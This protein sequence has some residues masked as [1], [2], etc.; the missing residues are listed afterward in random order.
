ML[1]DKYIDIFHIEWSLHFR[2]DEEILK[3]SQFNFIYT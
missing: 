3:L 2:D 1:E